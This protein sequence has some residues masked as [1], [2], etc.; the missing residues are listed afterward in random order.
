MHCAAENSGAVRDF[1]SSVSASNTANLKLLRQIDETCDW[2]ST[3]ER[4]ASVSSEFAVK[5]AEAI[6]A[7]EPRRPID[8]DNSIN[9]L[10]ID[11]ESG[12]VRLVNALSG[13]RE[14]AVR[15]PEL[16]GDHRE[17]VV[18]AYDRT[19]S[20]LKHLHDAMSELRWAIMEHDADSEPKPE[21]TFSSANDMLRNLSGE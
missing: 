9:D 3:I 5:H 14:A 21:E 17:A 10:I 1:C 2:L 12:L 19:I 7:C 13:K 8:P 6:R 20:E 4:Q 15:A 18:G 11:C 16:R